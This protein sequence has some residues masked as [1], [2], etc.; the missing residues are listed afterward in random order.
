MEIIELMSFKPSDSSATKMV[1]FEVSVAA[2]IPIPVESG[3]EHEVDLNEFLVD[4]PATTFFARVT[5]V[6]MV[7][8]GIRDGDILV[9]DS[10]IE[11]VDGRIVLAKLGDILTVKVIRA[12]NGEVF[13]E[14]HN[15]QFLPTQ[16]GELEF[17]IIGTVTKIIHSL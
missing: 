4:H 13:L 10:S 16:I 6:N 5:G 17:E 9:V 12:A 1:M 15:H 14:S 3:L 7:H 8:V 2:G 11:P